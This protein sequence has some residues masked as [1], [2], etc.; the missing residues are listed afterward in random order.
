MGNPFFKHYSHSHQHSKCC[1][2]M[3]LTKKFR[4]YHRY[5]L[6][7]PLSIILIALILWS[8]YNGKSTFLPNAVLQ[9]VL[10]LVI[11]KEMIMVGLSGRIYRQV[12]IP[13]EQLK[14]AVNSISE[15][16]YNIQVGFSALP[17]I[18]SL[19]DAINRMS[20]QLNES[21]KLKHLYETNRKELLANISHDLKT[22]IT[23][24]NGYIDGILDGIAETPE[25][26]ELYY[27]IIQ[28]NAR[29]MDKLIDDLVLYSKLDLQKMKFDF[30]PIPIDVYLNELYW[31]LKL[32]AEDNGVE[33]IYESDSNVHFI[34]PIDTKHFTRAIRNIVNNALSH[35]NID[36]PKIFISLYRKNDFISI[37]IKDNGPG[38]NPIHLPHIFERF[39]R[40][41]T[42]RSISNGS[43]G[44]GLSISKEIISAHKGI[45]TATNNHDSGACIEIFLPVPEEE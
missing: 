19:I 32:E 6:F 30:K 39:Y 25:K 35:G 5:F 8:Y 27:R 2:E 42:A 3:H 37:S 38:I 15:G 41:D 23:S 18:Q 11:L 22:P 26:Q 44:L 20:V 9:G 17:E 10:V 4:K 21:E 13:V 24:I 7:S 28:Q 29:Y 33:M 14:N 1:P 43:S 36:A 45:I 16:E 34:L 40:S 12:L 31:E